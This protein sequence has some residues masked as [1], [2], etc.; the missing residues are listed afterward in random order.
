MFVSRVKEIMKV[1]R[2]GN[3]IKRWE[4]SRLG[5]ERRCL[6][7]VLVRFGVVVALIVVVE[8]SV[9]GVRRVC[10]VHRA[11]SLSTVGPSRQSR[12]LALELFLDMDMSGSRRGVQ[13]EA[14]EVCPSGR[15]SRSRYFRLKCLE[16]ESLGNLVAC[17]CQASR[18][19]YLRARYSQSI[20]DACKCGSVDGS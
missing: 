3:A 6:V 9:C 12:Y 13:D 15:R 10:E 1:C 16:M 14:C 18:V 7:G 19:R 17:R 5:C 20:S 2:C 8:W 4:Q 11:R